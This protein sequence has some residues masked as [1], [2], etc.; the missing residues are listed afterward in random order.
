MAFMPPSS[1]EPPRRYARNAPPHRRDGRLRRGQPSRARPGGSNVK[2]FALALAALAAA[3]V[4]AAGAP[5]ADANHA[6][7]TM[8]NAAAGNAVL[9]FSRAADGTLTPS[10]AYPT[11]GRGG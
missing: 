7:Y 5:A 10:G 2:R 1:R 11:G 9:A 8:T 3:L 6:V 4:A